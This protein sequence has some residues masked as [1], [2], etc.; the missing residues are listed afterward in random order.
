MNIRLEMMQLMDQVKVAIDAEYIDPNSDIHQNFANYRFEEDFDSAM[1]AGYTFGAN[2][3]EAGGQ[4]VMHT[5]L[6]FMP[7]REG[8]TEDPQGGVRGCIP[9]RQHLSGKK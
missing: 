1:P 9:E 3:G 2:C 8:D 5:H 6:H 4:S 7:R